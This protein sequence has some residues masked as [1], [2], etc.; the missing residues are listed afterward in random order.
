MHVVPEIDK[1]H[2]ILNIKIAFVCTERFCKLCV[3]FIS[4]H[5]IDA[6]YEALCSFTEN[7]KIIS[8]KGFCSVSPHFDKRTL[9]HPIRKNDMIIQIENIRPRDTSFHSRMFI[10]EQQFG[11]S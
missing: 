10:H 9:A 2:Y 6:S 11:S 7:I 4:L 5:R 8:I 3:P 1:E